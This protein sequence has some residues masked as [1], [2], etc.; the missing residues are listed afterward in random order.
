MEEARHA[1]KW[2]TETDGNIASPM[3]QKDGKCD[4]YV[5]EPSLAEVDAQRTLGLVIPLR[6]FER[7]KE[8]WASVHC[9][10]VL[11]DGNHCIDGCKCS[12]IPLSS[13]ILSGVD[14]QSAQMRARYGIG[15]IKIKG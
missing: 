13:F 9:V 12:E 10:E 5:E 1:E 11:G 7:D 3:V 15:E 8:T 14:L 6:W 4:Y 2:R